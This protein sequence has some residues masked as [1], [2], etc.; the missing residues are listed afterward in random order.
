MGRRR[1]KCPSVMQKS[2]TSGSHGISVGTEVG[3][4]KTKVAVDSGATVTV[5]VA[6]G[7]ATTLRAGAQEARSNNRNRLNI[8]FMET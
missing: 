8:C 2:T 1:I 7:K 6:P 5:E 4:G 3:E